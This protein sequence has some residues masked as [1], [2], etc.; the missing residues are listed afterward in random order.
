MPPH[1]PVGLGGGQEISLV[2]EQHKLCGLHQPDESLS[3]LPEW[4]YQH[5]SPL[6]ELLCLQPS[7]TSLVCKVTWG[8]SENL[9]PR[10]SEEAEGRF[11]VLQLLS[12]ERQPHQK[13]A[14][15]S[16]A[17][18][19]P[20]SGQREEFFSQM[21]SRLIRHPHLPAWQIVFEKADGNTEALPASPLPSL[22]GDRRAL[23]S[24]RAAMKLKSALRNA[25]PQ[26]LSLH[27]GAILS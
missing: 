2:Q 16:T 20:T 24:A 21:A 4:H 13:A 12:P 15:K 3:K 26:S 9:P 19:N 8:F 11:G 14:E 22:G 5:P 6:A 18:G 17:K 25:S 27:N 10:Q 7:W 1:T 23:T